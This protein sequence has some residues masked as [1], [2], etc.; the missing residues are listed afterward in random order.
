MKATTKTKGEADVSL[1]ARAWVA[2][3]FQLGK[4]LDAAGAWSRHRSRLSEPPQQSIS[5]AANAPVQ[6]TM[7]ETATDTAT[8]ITA[9]DEMQL[10]LVL[11]DLVA[12]GDLEATGRGKKKRFQLVPRPTRV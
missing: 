9:L 3:L 6:L 7:P 10:A 11:D 8:E 2:S 4:D 1:A 12:S 5:A